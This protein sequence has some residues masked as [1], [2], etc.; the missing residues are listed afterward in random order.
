VAAG[1]V[2][3]QLPRGGAKRVPGTTV[4]LSVAEVPELRPLTS[5]WGEGGGHSVPFRIYGT[6]W[7]LFT[8]MSYQG[9]CTF[10]FICDGPTARIT[11]VKTGQTVAQF[12]LSEGTNKARTIDAGAGVYEITVSPGNDDA[13]WSVKVED[14]Y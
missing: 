14:Y 8:A 2:T 11:N 10:V 1:T 12:G 3:A 9:T 4:A 13:K 6:R 7:E 5:F